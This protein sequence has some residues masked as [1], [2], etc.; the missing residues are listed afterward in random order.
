[1]SLFVTLWYTGSF[2]FN[3]FFLGGEVI[4]FSLGG[5][6]SFTVV[7]FSETLTTLTARPLLSSKFG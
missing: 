5:G 6:G 4:F 7:L 2:N 3:D 1:M